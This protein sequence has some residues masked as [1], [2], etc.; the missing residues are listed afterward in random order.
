MKLVSFTFL[1]SIFL[2]LQGTLFS[3]PPGSLDETFATNGKFVLNNGFTDLFT[4][5]EITSDGKIV[6][7]GITYD[8]TWA[9]TTLVMRFNPDGSIDQTFANNGIFTFSL[10]AEANIFDLVI[11]PNG[12]ILMVGSTTDYNVY[13]FLIL[14]LNED[15]TPDDSFGVNGVVVKKFSPVTNFYE[16]HAYAVALMEDGRFVVAG[17]SHDLQYNFSPIVARFNENGTVDE[18]FGTN[19]AA[20]IPVLEVENDFDGVLV[21][22]DGKIVATGHIANNFLSFAMLVARFLPD[23][24]LDQTFDSDGVLNWVYSGV[25][26]EGYDIV[27][28]ENNEYLITG[29]TTTV[30]FNYSMLMIKLDQQGSFVSDFG[31]NGVVMADYGTYDV[32]SKVIVQG[33]GK[34]LVG[35]GSGTAPPGDSDFAFWRYLPDGT[36]DQTF[37]TDG[38][39][40][41][42]FFGNYDEALSIALQ[43]DGK[44]IAVGKANNGINHDFA[45][46]RLYNDISIG[47]NDMEKS[48]VLIS[49][50]PAVQGQLVII[51]F[52]MDTPGNVTVQFINSLGK[53]CGLA[54]PGYYSAGKNQVQV[55]VPTSLSN[56]VYLL[57]V[58]NGYVFKLLINK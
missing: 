2:V 39:A 37:G 10:D 5:L 53:V 20:R 4:D 22:P 28:T 52:E 21:Q 14:Q 13:N 41:V 11:R 51:E 40:K 12:K 54:E 8:V 48:S 33:D 7:V 49:P 19:G 16:D 58:N 29:F 30:T 25:D 50:N 38:M 42:Q 23:G 17:K 44:I 55:A 31:T 35:G 56:G 36:L 45:M 26:D 3:Q 34:I 32:G 46:I 9:A 57:R 43:S 18:T 24:T 15:G 27:L 6:A 47:V 1:I